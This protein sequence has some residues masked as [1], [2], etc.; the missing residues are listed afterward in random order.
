MQLNT[1]SQKHLTQLALLHISVIG[2]Q[3]DMSVFIH[4]IK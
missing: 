3:A 1:W 2:W 4:V